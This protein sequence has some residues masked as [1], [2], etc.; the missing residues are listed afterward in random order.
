VM[1]LAAVRVGRLQLG[2]PV[3]IAQQVAQ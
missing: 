3:V 1:A 2:C